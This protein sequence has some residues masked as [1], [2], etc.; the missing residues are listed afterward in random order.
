MSV[1]IISKFPIEINKKKETE[2]ISSE[3]ATNYLNSNPL[4]TRN[5]IHDIRKYTYQYIH[6]YVY[7]Y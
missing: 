7:I 6:E 3:E 5:E 4:Q 1:S 2:I